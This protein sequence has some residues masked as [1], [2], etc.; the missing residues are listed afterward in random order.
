[1]APPFFQLL[2]PNSVILDA[3]LSLRIQSANFI[4]STWKIYL[5]SKHNLSHL[6]LTPGPSHHQLPPALAVL[7][8]VLKRAP[9]EM[10]PTSRLHSHG[11]SPRSERKSDSWWRS[12]RPCVKQS[13]ASSTTPSGH[14]P[15][16]YPLQLR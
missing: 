4:S 6:Q 11:I 15:H 14:S 8:P 13:S 9:R 3:S 10:L 12:T 7:L 1:M 2:R 5:K 16:V